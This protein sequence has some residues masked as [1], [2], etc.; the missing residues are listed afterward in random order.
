MKEEKTM[1]NKKLV[2]TTLLLG[3]FSTGLVAKGVE[4]E[5]ASKPTITL[6]KKDLDILAK[7]KSKNFKGL[8]TKEKEQ[9]LKFLDDYVASAK[10]EKVAPK[11][12]DKKD[13]KKGKPSK[14]KATSKGAKKVKTKK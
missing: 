8:S 6:E 1:L 10:K 2:I 7:A 11:I 9:L 3:L 12:D 13:K 14:D 5:E 4:F